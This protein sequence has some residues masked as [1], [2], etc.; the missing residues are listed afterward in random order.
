MPAFFKIVGASFYWDP[1]LWGGGKSGLVVLRGRAIF[2]A[3]FALLFS[4]VLASR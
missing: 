3:N 1:P 2:P 4:L